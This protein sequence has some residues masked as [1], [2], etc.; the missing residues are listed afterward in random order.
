MADIGAGAIE[1]RG[2]DADGPAGL[3]AISRRGSRS[4]E[5]ES[6]AWLVASPPRSGLHRLDGFARGRGFD[7]AVTRPRATGTVASSASSATGRSNQEKSHDG[8]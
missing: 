4:V 2:R 6:R 3:C 7:R 1:P 5:R 8:R